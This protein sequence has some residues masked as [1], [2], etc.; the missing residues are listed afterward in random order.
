MNSE[1]LQ[2]APLKEVLLELHWDLEFVSEQGIE[3]DRDFE[4]A[5]FNFSQACQQNYNIVS[6]LKPDNIPPAAFAHRVTH[7]FHKV[8]G[9]H[10]LYQLGPGVFTIN[11]N[12]K[13]YKWADFRQMVEFGI[14]CLQASYDRSLV[15][16]K[17]EIRYIDRMSPYVLGNPD[18]FSFMQEHLQVNPTPFPFVDG[19]MVQIQI[20][21]RFVAN[22]QTALTL[23][24][25]TGMDPSSKEDVVEWHTFVTNTKR[26]S[27]DSLLE[28]IDSAH[29]LCSN[30][31]KNMISKDLYEYFSN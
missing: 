31:F 3:V 27:W 25:T 30:S 22:E 4:R 11:D 20:S 9:Q 12:N 10:P 26:L 14:Q 6:I 2:K 18:K 28:W 24:V 17:V 23:I 8:K 13:N 15:L 19:E 1:F 5:V 16:S 7:R 29:I 21:Q